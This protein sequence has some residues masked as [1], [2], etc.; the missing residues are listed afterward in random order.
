MITVILGT[1]VITL[2]LIVLLREAVAQVEDSKYQQREDVLLAGT[3][4]AVDRYIT[5]LNTDPNYWLLFVDHAERARICGAGVFDGQRK[6]PPVLPATATPW[7][8]DCPVWTYDDP[9]SGDWYVVPGVADAEVQLEVT[10]PSGDLPLSLFVVGRDLTFPDQIRAVS[11]DVSPPAVSEFAWLTELDLR[12]GPGAALLGPVYS[13]NDVVFHNGSGSGSDAVFAD[14]TIGPEPVN[15]ADLDLYDTS[16]LLGPPEHLDIREIYPNVLNFDSFWAQI[17]EIEV[18]ACDGDLFFCQGSGSYAAYRV[19]PYMGAGLR[20][21]IEGANPPDP[22]VLHDGCVDREEWWWLRYDDA[23][24][25]VG[26]KNTWQFI[27]D[28]AVPVDG[29]IW[30]DRTVVLG[31]G[32][33]PMTGL[34]GQLT[35]VAGN[36]AELADIVITEDITVDSFDDGDTLGLIASDELV[37]SPYSVTGGDASLDINAALLAQSDAVRVARDCGRWGTVL[38]QLPNKTLNFE[39]AI[40]TRNTGDLEVHFDTRNYLWNSN[41][42]DIRPPLF[43]LMSGNWQPFNWTE[44]TIPTW[45]P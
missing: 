21:R 40:A 8:A 38:T 24:N 6:E 14:N 22:S 33:D 30:L 19:T 32:I 16:G 7:F 26:K 20:V 23:L 10:P 15:G 3:E 13:G 17:A 25:P 5:N 42:N 4:A 31:D 12:F 44:E 29:L 37:F 18:Q 9:D 2:A 11:V 39:G 34:Q 45:V 35:I 43:P 1:A 41:F 36:E 28:K 27:D